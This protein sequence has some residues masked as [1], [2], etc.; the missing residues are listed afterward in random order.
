MSLNEDLLQLLAFSKLVWVAV[1][2][3]LYGLGGM[4][5]KYKRRVFMPV[6]LGLGVVISSFIEHYFSWWLLLYPPLL[7]GTLSM[8]YSGDKLAKKILRRALYGIMAALASLPVA[9]VTQ[10]WLLFGLHLFVCPVFSVI[11]GAWN[12]TSAREEESLIGAAAGTLPLFY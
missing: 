9:F 2:A 8:G 5:G 12:P 10:D 1:A 4:K 6:W 11:L 7:Y 3:L